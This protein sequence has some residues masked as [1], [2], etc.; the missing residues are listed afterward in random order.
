MYEIYRGT[1]PTIKYV[2]DVV[3]VEDISEAFLTITSDGEVVVDRN[4]PF[5]GEDYL[6]WTLTQEET[7]SLGCSVFVQCN[8]LLND[9][10]RGSSAKKQIKVLENLHDEVMP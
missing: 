10:T 4:S 8:W 2:F 6:S 3:K 1:T 7:F 9:G 5:V